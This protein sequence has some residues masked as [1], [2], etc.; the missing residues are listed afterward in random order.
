MATQTIITKEE[1][2]D[3]LTPYVNYLYLKETKIKNN[4][5][6][7]TVIKTDISTEGRTAAEEF[8]KAN[9]FALAGGSF[10]E[11]S[12]PY[13]FDTNYKV[14]DCGYKHTPLNDKELLLKQNIAAFTIKAEEMGKIQSFVEKPCSIDKIIFSTPAK[15]LFNAYELKLT[16]DDKDSIFESVRKSS[17][18]TS[19]KLLGWMFDFS[20]VMKEYLVTYSNGDIE[21]VYAPDETSIRRNP[22]YSHVSQIKE[23]KE[24]CVCDNKKDDAI[25]ALLEAIQCNVEQVEENI[26]TEGAKDLAPVVRLQLISEEI[27]ILQGLISES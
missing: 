11:K 14:I 21:R 17:C 25:K 8:A 3:R 16:R 9:N 19:I 27:E 26:F 5:E 13:N 12:L 7:F 4:Q 24:D 10:Y 15:L 2:Q 23:I 18:S 6:F 1:I 20:F 22:Y